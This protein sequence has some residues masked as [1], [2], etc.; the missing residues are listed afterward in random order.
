MEEQR[1]NSGQK[2]TTRC[3]EN[4]EKQTVTK[5]RR[6]KAPWL[7]VGE[8]FGVSPRYDST[9]LKP[10]VRGSFTFLST[11]LILPMSSLSFSRLFPKVER[12]TLRYLMIVREGIGQYRLFEISLEKLRWHALD[13]VHDSYALLLVTFRSYE[14]SKWRVSLLVYNHRC[15]SVWIIFILAIIYMKNRLYQQFLLS[16]FVF[17]ILFLLLYQITFFD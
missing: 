2:R 4:G 10:V 5:R 11:L 6:E 1:T 14:R 17:S 9:R 13:F 8:A 3:V 16:L 12:R 7:L 15:I